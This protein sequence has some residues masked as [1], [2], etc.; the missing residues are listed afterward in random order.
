MERKKNLDKTILVKVKEAAILI[1][2]IVLSENVEMLLYRIYMMGQKDTV[3]VM[4][5]LYE[6][7]PCKF[8]DYFEDKIY[9]NM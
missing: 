4:C 1:E 7:D 3:E 2:D 8:E 9:N 5:D 6:E